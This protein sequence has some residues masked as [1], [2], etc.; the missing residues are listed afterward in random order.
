LDARKLRSP[1]GTIV[2]V[3]SEGLAH[4]VATEWNSQNGVVKLDRMPLVRVY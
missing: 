1:S 2:K 4:A 3:P